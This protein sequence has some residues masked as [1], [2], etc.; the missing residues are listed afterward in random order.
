MS[1][2]RRSAVITMMTSIVLVAVA[3]P[4][5]AQDALSDPSPNTVVP[6]V[7]TVQ[8]TVLTDGAAVETE[9]TLEMEGQPVMLLPGELATDDEARGLHMAGALNQ[10]AQI[11]AFSDITD[12]VAWQREQRKDRSLP[13]RSE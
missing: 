10:L 7:A 9:F 3:I 5:V 4:A 8:A 12:P 6:E 11:N 2:V 1:L 13:T